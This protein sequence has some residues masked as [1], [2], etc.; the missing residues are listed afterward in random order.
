MRERIITIKYL[1]GM[2]FRFCPEHIP[3][4]F[5]NSLVSSM[6]SILWIVIL[7]NIVNMYQ[8][9]E[10][11][12]LFL[13]GALLVILS[14]ILRSII[15]HLK[16]KIMLSNK[17]LKDKI[18]LYIDKKVMELDYEQTESPKVIDL[19]EKAIWTF[20]NYGGVTYFIQYFTNCLTSLVM[21]IGYMIILLPRLPW[22]CVCLLLLYMG[23]MF[24][25]G[26]FQRSCD[27]RYWNHITPLNRKFLYL[28]W[29]VSHN[30]ECGKDIRM[31]DAAS[32]VSDQL[33]SMREQ[34]RNTEADYHRDLWKNA[35]GVDIIQIILLL[36]LSI[37]ILY[38]D[39]AV[40]IKVLYI[41]TLVQ[42][43][44]ETERLFQ[45]ISNVLQM[46]SYGEYITQ[47]LKINSSSEQERH[48]EKIQ[49]DGYEI[50]F[51]NVSFAYPGNEEMVLK[52]VSFLWKKGERIAIVGRN[53]AGKSTVVKLLC[54]LYKPTSGEILVNGKLIQ[55]IN[56]LE[57]RKMLGVVFQDFKLF[58][59]SIRE[60]IILDQRE[61]VKM[62]QKLYE[63]Y[64]VETI[65]KKLSE[66]DR[67]NL[68]KKFDSKG[69]ELSGGEKQEIAITRAFYKEPTWV[70]LDE[71]SSALDAKAEE[72]LYKQVISQEQK[73]GL[74][75]VSHR[76]SSCKLCDVILV[77]RGGEIIERGDHVSLMD[78]KGEYYQL[79]T[80]QAEMYKM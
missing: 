12:G 27:K 26:K 54:R 42:F 62:L 53:G 46:A 36:S 24:L 79:F 50:E 13:V 2:S 52:N 29:N 17:I 68:D 22:L 38:Q 8:R 18:D 15:I 39:L 32:M 23:V 55:N 16:N 10:Y 74:F 64:G 11:N 43:L 49:N 9:K 7:P 14:F 3:C 73:A 37:I 41:S 58:P 45:G 21:V 1:L 31:Y 25:S 4:V 30:F 70:I 44:P 77:M 35:S 63:V 66:G 6:I 71:P 48:D 65:I 34:W 67:T 28:T 47:F 61:N 59:F 72:T 60:N 20:E 69:T 5:L 76:L 57:Y 40:A 33:K 56:L 19:K 51:R 75:F 80:T 78:K